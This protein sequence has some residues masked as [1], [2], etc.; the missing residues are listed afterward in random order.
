M[1][2]HI[3]LLFLI[4]LSPCIDAVSYSG[5]LPVLFIE[6]ANHEAVTSKDNY[7]SGTYY[8]DPMGIS[9]I[10]SIGSQEFP[11][12]LQIKGRGNWT[13]NGFDKKPY[14]LKL[15]SK[16]ALMGL[17][18]NK[19]FALLAHADDDKGFMRNTIGF[20]MSE[21]IGLAWTPKQRPVELVLNGD[22]IGLY[23]LTELIRVDKD[24]VNITEQADSITDPYLITGG[25]LVEIDNYDTDPHIEITEGD[26][27]R[28][29]ITHKSPEI[30][31]SPQT[32]FL[33]NEITR[34]DQL[35][36]GN[37]QSDELWNYLDIDALARFYIVQE[38]TDNYESFHGSCYLHRNIGYDSKWTF[39]PVWDFGSSFN[40]DKSQYFYQ[41]REWHNTWIEEIR[42]FPHFMDTVQ[43]IWQDFYA[44][45]YNDIY[46][47]INLFSS[48]IEQAACADAARWNNQGYGNPDMSAK[49]I[50]LTDR[51]QATAQWLCEQ[52]GERT[53]I[54]P[55]A[56]EGELPLRYYTLQ[57]ILIHAPLQ[58][59]PF[60][61]RQGS[62]A[63][64]HY[65]P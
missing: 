3:F 23:F 65:I 57:G 14:R 20:W 41:G 13:W 21:H 15:E 11:L 24:R 55:I 27:S 9:G 6:T 25:W 10:D 58:G 12:P 32:A 39:G 1:K 36:Y 43:K 45:Q 49:R 53:N 19:H 37:K 42:R 33:S 56:A 35:I 22:Y 5:T 28:L 8:L 54:N 4:C 51:L 31:S 38:I 29:V 16:A 34:L 61:V 40:Y 62:R 18:A 46:A 60:I 44:T 7:L 2:Q 30:L 52:W 50:L 64:V 48:Q 17:K 59:Q 47:Y 63:K 26:G